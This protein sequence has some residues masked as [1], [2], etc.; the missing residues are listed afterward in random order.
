MSTYVP[1]GPEVCTCEGEE[2]MGIVPQICITAVGLYSRPGLG[3]LLHAV[4]KVCIW[5]MLR[6]K[7]KGLTSQDWEECAS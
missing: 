5:H 6:M 3:S 2:N 7:C 4:G 1:E